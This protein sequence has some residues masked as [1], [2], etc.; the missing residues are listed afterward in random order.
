MI[1]VLRSAVRIC[2]AVCVFA[3]A[4]S[5]Q[6][7]GKGQPARLKDNAPGDTTCELCDPV[8][9]GSETYENQV[10]ACERGVALSCA[11]LAHA[12]HG[13]PWC[14]LRGHTPDKV[15]SVLYI[16]RACDLGEENACAELF[17]L[18]QRFAP[19]GPELAAASCKLGS[20]QG[21]YAQG[22][23]V[24][25]G[26]SDDS[27]KDGGAT[28]ERVRAAAARAYPFYQQACDLGH[29]D[30]CANV[31]LAL[32]VGHMGVERDP[33][34]AVRV[35]ERACK[36]HREH[37]RPHIS[38]GYACPWLAQA[39]WEG[40]GTPRNRDLARRLQHESCRRDDLW[41]D[42]LPLVARLNVSPWGI[43]LPEAAL[44]VAANLLAA[45]LI[46]WHRAWAALP[47]RRHALCNLSFVTALVLGC[48]SG[49]QLWYFF[50]GSPRESFAWALVGLLA[51][52]M[53]GALLVVA[54]KRRPAAS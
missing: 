29:V 16:E 6:P 7:T 21:C 2:L 45:I 25:S 46:F 36:S 42:D 18:T 8:P 53:P 24:A 19:H 9:S 5:K 30:A 10:A 51:V 41:C 4:C 1:A 52:V 31:G 48:A 47:R 34:K 23:Y 17:M 13:P 15:R 40:M 54:R 50:W 14:C 32:R 37:P 33:R 49:A 27:R 26:W 3:A 20:A 39:Y 43:W 11:W 44:L 38:S 12:W 22:E 35:L 28:P